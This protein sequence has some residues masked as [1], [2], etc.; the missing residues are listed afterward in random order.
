MAVL[1]E[2]QIRRRLKLPAKDSRSLIVTPLLQEKTAFS[3]DSIDLR[4]GCYFLLPQVPPAPFFDP[5]L[6]R[7]ISF[8]VHVPIGEYLVLP[9]H[10]TVLGATLEFVK[11]P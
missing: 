11:L 3:T 8:Q 7:S 1:S 2:T 10:Q 6:R 4:L 5:N 9:A